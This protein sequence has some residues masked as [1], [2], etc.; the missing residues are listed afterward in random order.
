MVNEIFWM[1]GK[2][3]TP[4]AKVIGSHSAKVAII[5][6][7]VAGLTIADELLRSGIHDVVILEAG[8]CGSGA[9]G[10]SS[11]F[12]TPASELELSQLRRRFGDDDTRILW[13]AA[14]R[15]CDAIGETIQRYQLDCGFLAADSLY[16]ASDEGSF[17]VVE[18]EHET[19]LA[20]GY[21]SRLYDRSSVAQV[22]GS[23]TFGG[24]VRYGRTFA[25]DSFEYVRTLSERLAQQ[26]VQIFEGSA[27]TSVDGG[28]ARTR[29]GSVR[30]ESIFF[31]LDHRACGIGVAKQEAYHAQTFLTISEPLDEALARSIFPDGPQ[32]VWDTDLIYQYFRLTPDRRLLLGGGLLSRTYA[33]ER[34]NDGVPVQHLLDYVRR[35]FPQIEGV[36]FESM[37]PGLIGVTKDLLPLAGKCEGRPGHYAA[38]CSSGLPWSVLAAR[39]AVQIAIDGKSELSDF[40]DPQRSFTELD[41]TQPVVR[42]PLTFAL[43]HAYAKSLLKGDARRVSQRKQVIKRVSLGAAIAVLLILAWRRLRRC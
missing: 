13:N 24:A 16:I 31:S 17:D 2:K 11:G 6:G 22:I 9:S 33:P 10:R 21:E 43:S 34:P 15:G 25:I 38:L 27:V 19:R 7:G 30:A 18:E 14:Q 40:L 28:V 39:V 29:E 37:W 32:L 5:G 41:L 12:I 42:K 20:L 3:I 35:R 23:D 1:R 26:G 36:R 8:F 4:R